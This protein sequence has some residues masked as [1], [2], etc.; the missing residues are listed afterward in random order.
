MARRSVAVRHRLRRFAWR[1][2]NAGTPDVVRDW[3]RRYV[4]IAT[5]VLAAA[6][7]AVALE[8]ETS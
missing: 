6:I 5:G 4:A 7:N 2:G 8:K 1:S 3:D